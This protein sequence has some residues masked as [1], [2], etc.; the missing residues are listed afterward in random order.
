[1]HTLDEICRRFHT[2]AIDIIQETG[3]INMPTYIT[4]MWTRGVQNDG[5]VEYQTETYIFGDLIKHYF[6]EN[7]FPED[8]FN[9]MDVI[10]M[11]TKEKD[12]EMIIFCSVAFENKDPYPDDPAWGKPCLLTFVMSATGSKEVYVSYFTGNKIDEN[13]KFLKGD[14]RGIP[15]AQWRTAS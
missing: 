12:P 9:G 13:K 15:F 3:E 14:N 10:N 2:G 11:I 5:Q 8:E 7:G 1:M 6:E 4:L